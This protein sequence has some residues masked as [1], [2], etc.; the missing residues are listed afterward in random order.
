MTSSTVSSKR[1][2]II[3]HSGFTELLQAERRGFEHAAGVHGGGVSQ[4]ATIKEADRAF[5]DRHGFRVASFALC[6]PAARNA[7]LTR[8]HL[9]IGRRMETL[10]VAFSER[11]NRPDGQTLT[12][13]D[14]VGRASGG[15][16][17]QEVRPLDERESDLPVPDSGLE[18]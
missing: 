10:A 11:T 8:F 1:C 13:P 16:G 4:T 17:R 15:S 9:I 12:F 2:V 7:K 3:Q 14:K 18:R 6:S 5:T